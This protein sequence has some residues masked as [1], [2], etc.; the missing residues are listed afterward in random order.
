MSMS[1][2]TAATC[3]PE[4]MTVILLGSYWYGTV[5]IGSVAG[6]NIWCV[7][8]LSSPFACAVKLTG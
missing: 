1:S 4:E 3:S 5:H 8:S 2:S 6:E 7:F